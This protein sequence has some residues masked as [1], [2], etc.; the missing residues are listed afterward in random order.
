MDNGV[1]DPTV[2][3]TLHS[4]TF[5]PPKVTDYFSVPQALHSSTQILPVSDLFTLY[6]SVIISEHG[7]K[8]E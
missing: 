4:I 6:L 5:L 8:V 2:G 3:D 1:S 7:K